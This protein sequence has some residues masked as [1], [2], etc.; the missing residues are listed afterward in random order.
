M[1]PLHPWAAV[2]SSCCA[3]T[4]GRSKPR[5]RRRAW[6]PCEWRGALRRPKKKA[7]QIGALKNGWLIYVNMKLVGCLEPWNFM[8][9]HSVGNV[10]IPT[11]YIIFFQRG[12]YTTKQEKDAKLVGLTGKIGM[13]MDEKRDKRDF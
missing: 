4:V 5:P 7:V 2:T 8:T 6:W 12:R 1:L 10:I 13:A 11:D 9:F 3:A